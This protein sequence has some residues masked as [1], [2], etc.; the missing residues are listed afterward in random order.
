MLL[1]LHKW[2]HRNTEVKSSNYVKL[3]P[4]QQRGYTCGP[5]AY[6]HERVADFA[7]KYAYTQ[8]GTVVGILITAPNICMRTLAFIYMLVHV[9]ALEP[10]EPTHT[11]HTSCVQQELTLGS[12]GLTLCTTME[13]KRPGVRRHRQR[14]QQCLTTSSQVSEPY[15]LSYVNGYYRPPNSSLAYCLR[16]SFKWHNETLNFWTHFSLVA[17]VV[18]YCWTFPGGLWPLTSVRAKYYPLLAYIAC[19]FGLF[20]FSSMAH[21]LGCT[22]LRVFHFSLFMDY[23]AMCVNGVGVGCASFWY[24]RPVNGSSFVF[25][26]L[27]SSPHYFL[28]LLS[29]ASMLA[30]YVMCGTIAKHRWSSHDTTVRTAAI[31]VVFIIGQIPS[32][33]RLGQ[34]VFLDKDC[35]DGTFYVSLGY[36]FYLMGSLMYSLKIPER[37]APGKFD[38][39]GVGHQFMHVFVALGSMSY[40]IAIE[41]DL[42]ERE[43]FLHLDQVTFASSLAWVLTTIVACLMIVLWSW[44]Q[45]FLVTSKDK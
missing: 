16:S 6:P 34:C 39:V 42:R 9:H 36:L 19:F 22:S 14:H 44:R 7:S 38:L 12:P 45:C 28:L 35:S 21:L 33:D 23:A 20:F 32:A 40:K 1:W 41:S 26:F 31:G 3:L 25:R 15:R 17:V 10:F 29:A 43:H 2:N 11:N 27:L 8:L 5:Y 30:C 37:W 18:T 4:V 24:E 13:R